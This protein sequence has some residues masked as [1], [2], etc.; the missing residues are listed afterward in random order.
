MV[1]LPGGRRATMVERGVSFSFQK[2]EE[3]QMQERVGSCKTCN[4]E[5]F[6]NDGFINGVVLEDK[7][8]VCFD[9][10]EEAE[11]TAST[12]NAGSGSGEE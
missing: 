5:V 11:K 7:T 9:C 6:C 3:R 4:R 8:L 1:F 2:K 12:E 10:F